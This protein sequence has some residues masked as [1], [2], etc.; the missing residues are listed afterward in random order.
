MTRGR[1]S[2][3]TV[4]GCALAAVAALAVA[5]RQGWVVLNPPPARQ[6]IDLIFPLLALLILGAL[7]WL[8]QRIW[9]PARPL[10]Q[11][12]IAFRTL[13]STVLGM[14]FLFT[15]LWFSIGE[16]RFDETTVLPLPKDLTLLS[17]TQD[18]GSELCSLTYIIATPEGVPISEL[19]RR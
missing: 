12:T 1:W 4:G 13:L 18:C 9:P 14:A 2:L 16:E 6:D 19:R 3:W 17:R 8:D 7:V 5:I 15:A 10:T 11:G